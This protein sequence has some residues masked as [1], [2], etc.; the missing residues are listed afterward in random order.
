MKWIKGVA[1]GLLALGGT[2]AY[3]TLCALAMWGRP[4]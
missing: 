3:A 1:W 4:A 2:L